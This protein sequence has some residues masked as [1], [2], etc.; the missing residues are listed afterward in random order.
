M[1]ICTQAGTPIIK[2]ISQSGAFSTISFNFLFQSRS[3]PIFFPGLSHE[4]HV[5]WS[6]HYTGIEAAYRPEDVLYIR[7]EDLKN[8]KIRVEV[9]I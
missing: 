6:Q 4:Y 3:F 8:E 7:Y 1:H 9:G 2:P 5:M